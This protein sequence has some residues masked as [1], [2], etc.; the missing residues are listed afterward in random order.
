[1]NKSNVDNIN[2]NG[3]DMINKDFLYH[4]SYDYR[5][6][7]IGNTQNDFSFKSNSDLID[8]LGKSG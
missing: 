2:K 1:M 7:P 8:N 5:N 3:N 6:A 4:A